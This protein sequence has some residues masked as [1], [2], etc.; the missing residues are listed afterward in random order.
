MIE[1]FKLE[2]VLGKIIEFAKT[3]N[4]SRYIY[5]SMFIFVEFYKSSSLGQLKQKW[6]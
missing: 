6:I 4:G 5:D 3:Y 1:N 2:D